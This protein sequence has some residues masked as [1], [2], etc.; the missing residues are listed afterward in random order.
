MICIQLS[1]CPSVCLSV[2]SKGT[3]HVVTWSEVDQTYRYTTIYIY[4]LVVCIDA[5]NS[6][7]HSVTIVI[8]RTNTRTSTWSTQSTRAVV[9]DLLGSARRK[10]ANYNWCSSAKGSRG[11]RKTTLTQLYHCLEAGVS[12]RQP[13][14]EAIEDR[15]AQHLLQNLIYAWRRSRHGNNSWKLRGTKETCGPLWTTVVQWCT[16]CSLDMPH[17]RSR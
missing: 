14:V 1:V 7:Q 16:S 5:C 9:S 15:Q 6:I 13:H 4:R 10:F 3:L 8:T 17:S 2:W 12:D 11:R